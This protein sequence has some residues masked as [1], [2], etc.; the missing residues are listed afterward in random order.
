MNW[1]KAR[2]RHFLGLKY[3]SP[4]RVSK[5]VSAFRRPLLALEELETRNLLTAVLPAPAAALMPYPADNPAFPS[6]FDAFNPPI[7]NVSVVSA[8]PQLAALTS[9]GNP[10][11]SLTVTGAQFS[12]LV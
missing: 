3:T 1:V 12:A 11:D 4:S 6:G 5:T 8:A 9:Q 10:D 7:A 2:L